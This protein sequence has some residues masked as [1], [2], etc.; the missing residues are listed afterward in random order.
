M[1]LIQ[2]CP[3]AEAPDR[4]NTYYKYAGALTALKKKLHACVALTP[5][6]RCLVVGRVSVARKKT[7]PRFEPPMPDP[8]IFCRG[9]AF[10][11]FLFSKGSSS[12]SPGPW[13][14]SRLVVNGC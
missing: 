6:L 12:P 3:E 8:P 14:S 10:R 7:M 1:I 4:N 5:Q 11:E 2:V 13:P 9:E